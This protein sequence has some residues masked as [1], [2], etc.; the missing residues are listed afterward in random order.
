ME[1][2]KSE[3]KLSNYMA[4]LRNL[5]N[6]IEADVSKDH[7][8]RVLM[9]LMDREN[10]KHSRQLPFRFLSAYKELENVDSA[11]SRVFDSLETA[12]EMSIE[13]MEKFKGTTAIIVDVSGSMQSTVSAK[14]KMYCSE[15]ALLLGVMGAK[16]CDEHFF[17]TFD[18]GLYRPKVSSKGG[19]ISQM[20]SIPVQGGGTNVSLPFKCLVD[21]KINVDRI[22]LLSDNQANCGMTRCQSLVDEYRKTVN[23]D[24]WIHGWD[25]QG[26]GSVV[27][28]PNDKRTN[29]IS[30]WSEKGF[31]LMHLF[32]RGMG[33][34]VKEIKNYNYSETGSIAETS[35]M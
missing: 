7:L 17:L 13:N 20:K 21:T 10:V 29:F 23:K 14:S 18:T 22:I 3:Y 28:N 19:I 24:V 25:L 12:L 31:A 6:I 5:R 34:L 35:E 9:G 32:E 2:S 8:N 16:I 30:G 33:S 4:A 27:L 15:I 1:K 26:Y 11:S